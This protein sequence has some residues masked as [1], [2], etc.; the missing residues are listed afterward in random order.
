MKRF[1]CSLF[2]LFAFFVMLR[3]G[4]ETL[5]RDAVGFVIVEKEYGEGADKAVK[6]VMMFCDKAGKGVG[7]IP[8]DLV[9][10]AIFIP[11]DR[12]I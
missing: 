9:H 10:L 7:V 6:P 1:I 8:L 2:A 3:G 4:A 5:V 11:D 12:L